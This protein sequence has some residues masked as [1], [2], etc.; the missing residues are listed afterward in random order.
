MTKAELLNR[1]ADGKGVDSS[2]QKKFKVKRAGKDK[3]DIFWAFG[4]I[5]GLENIALVSREELEACKGD[6]VKIQRLV[7]AANDN[8]KP[9]AP[10]SYEEL[11]D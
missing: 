4:K 9:A 7:D 6:P 11:V 1:L 3:D 5:H 2:F 10:K 8:E